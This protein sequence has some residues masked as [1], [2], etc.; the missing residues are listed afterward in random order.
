ML[1]YEVFFFQVLAY[2]TCWN[3][4]ASFLELGGYFFSK[5]IDCKIEAVYLSWSRFQHIMILVLHEEWLCFL[6]LVAEKVHAGRKKSVKEANMQVDVT[7]GIEQ[8]PWESSFL[9]AFSIFYWATE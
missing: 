3:K 4:W 1:F 7:L 9:C 6:F 5:T 8:I 2:I